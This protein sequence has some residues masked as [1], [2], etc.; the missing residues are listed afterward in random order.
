LKCYLHETEWEDRNWINMAQDRDKWLSLVNR[1]M[2]LQ[3]ST[4]WT[5]NVQEV[6]SLGHMIFSLRYRSSIRFRCTNATDR[7]WTLFWASWTQSTSSHPSFRTHFNIVIPPSSS[8]PSESFPSKLP[9]KY[10]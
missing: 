7:H 9:A 4:N 8:L 5:K 2:N 6:A 10:F 1:V 3:S